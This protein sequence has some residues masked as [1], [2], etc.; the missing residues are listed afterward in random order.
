VEKINTYPKNVLRVLTM[1][2]RVHRFM[3]KNMTPLQYIMKFMM[4]IPVR[5]VYESHI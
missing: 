1:A 5:P 4:L 3:K 2:G